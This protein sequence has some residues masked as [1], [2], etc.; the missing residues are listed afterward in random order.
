MCKAP[1]ADMGQD[2]AEPPQIQCSAHNVLMEGELPCTVESQQ[3]GPGTFTF[4][5]SCRKLL[6]IVTAPKPLPKPPAFAHRRI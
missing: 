5:L 3:H 1:I 4:H 2:A 6:A